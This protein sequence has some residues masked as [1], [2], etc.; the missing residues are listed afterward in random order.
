MRDCEAI[1]LALVAGASLRDVTRQFPGVSKDGASQ[2]REHVAAAMVA[3]KTV[4]DVVHGETLIEKV[5]ALE[6]QAR[7]IGQRA[8]Q[9]GDLRI[10]LSAIRELTRITELQAKLAG[11]LSD[12][13]TVN[14]TLSTDRL[15][16]RM[17]VLA[18]L[19]KYPAARL[20]VA[21]ALAS[22]AGDVDV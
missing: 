2:H 15:A 21:G 17:A 9:A 18:A 3:A 19:E 13:P 20:A 8:E 6:A 11:E 10:A 12:S 7:A 14:I 5:Q 16:I 1:D 4:A 22:R